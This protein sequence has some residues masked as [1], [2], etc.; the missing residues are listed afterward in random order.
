MKLPKGSKTLI[1]FVLFPTGE[2]REE[3]TRGDEKGNDYVIRFAT[4]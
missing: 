4:L 3:E 1:S 2:N